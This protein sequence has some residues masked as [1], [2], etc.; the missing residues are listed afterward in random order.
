MISQKRRS[1]ILPMPRRIMFAARTRIRNPA[2]AL[3]KVSFAILANIT[4]AWLLDL[5]LSLEL[6]HL[7]LLYHAE[8]LL[9]L[10]DVVL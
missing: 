5:F 9:K 6:W 8:V 4:H 7:W 10:A 2:K 1:L 3:P